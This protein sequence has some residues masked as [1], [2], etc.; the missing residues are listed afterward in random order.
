MVDLLAVIAHW[1][2][3]EADDADARLADLDGNDT[4][5]VNDLLRVISDWG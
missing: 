4:I 3:V 2:V 5:D 1:G